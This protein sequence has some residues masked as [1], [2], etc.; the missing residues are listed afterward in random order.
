[1]Y[2][3]LATIPPS[4]SSLCPS[5]RL[6]PATH[7]L[8]FS[9]LTAIAGN[10]KDVQSQRRGL[11][12][13][14]AARKCVYRSFRPLT[15]SG[16]PCWQCRRVLSVSCACRI[17]S[18]LHLPRPVSRHRRPAAVGSFCS[19]ERARYVHGIPWRAS[20]RARQTRLPKDEAHRELV[21]RPLRDPG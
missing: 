9:L 13:R 18:A 17:R 21:T 20:C 16:L 14:M 4:H 5:A 15:G 12:R 7:R 3:K 19:I 8:R 6:P 11:P 2:G 1:M 10:S